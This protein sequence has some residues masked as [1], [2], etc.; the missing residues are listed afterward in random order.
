LHPIFWAYPNRFGLQPLF[1]ELRKRGAPDEI[2]LTYRRAVANLAAFDSAKVL[3]QAFTSAKFENLSME[4][5]NPFISAS[6]EVV[7]GWR[8]AVE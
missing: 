7:R 6:F 8:K 5:I 4:Q 3:N 2:V 1:G